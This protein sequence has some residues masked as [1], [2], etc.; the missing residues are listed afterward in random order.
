MLIDCAAFGDAPAG[1]F[2]IGDSVIFVCFY[3]V[4]RFGYLEE[5]WC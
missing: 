4:Q 1:S 2:T 3:Q 5:S